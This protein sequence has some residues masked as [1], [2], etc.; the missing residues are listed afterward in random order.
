MSYCNIIGDINSER[1]GCN[2][3]MQLIV[4]CNGY[5]QKTIN[6]EIPE[7]YDIE[8]CLNILYKAQQCKKN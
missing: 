8:A 5:F 2:Y 6:K 1:Q 3:N 4:L 7:S